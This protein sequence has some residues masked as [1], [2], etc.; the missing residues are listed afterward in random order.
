MREVDQLQHAVHERVADGDERVDT[1]GG[2][3]TDDP[4]RELA[5]QTGRHVALGEEEG[6]TSVTPSSIKD[7]FAYGVADEDA[8]IAPL[9]SAAFPSSV[10]F[11]FCTL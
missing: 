5:R 7:R 4:E 1:P 2:Q 3:T 8:F 6:V 9:R 10:Y 11:E